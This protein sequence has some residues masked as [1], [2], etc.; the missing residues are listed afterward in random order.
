MKAGSNLEKVLKGGHFAVTTELVPPKGTDISIIKKKAEFL[1]GMADAI[2]VT[3][4]QT[5]V[6]RMS[7]ISVSAL[8]IQMGM[9]P[10]MQMTCRD[11]NRIAMQ[12]DIFAH[13]LSE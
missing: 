9:E 6:P 1:K 11:R 5:A 12:S 7:S 13:L 10:V 4:C 2:N 3:D 8:L